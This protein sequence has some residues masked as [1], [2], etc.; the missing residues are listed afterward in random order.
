MVCFLQAEIAALES[1]QSSETNMTSCSSTDPIS[2]APSTSPEEVRLDETSRVEGGES[3]SD[4]LAA[5][6]GMK[7][8]LVLVK[9]IVSYI[10]S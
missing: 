9:L 6:E 3:I 4:E 1:T 10:C 7:V 2:Q 8:L 5:L